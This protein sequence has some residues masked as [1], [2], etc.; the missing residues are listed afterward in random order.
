MVVVV[1]GTHKTGDRIRGTGACFAG[2]TPYAQVVPT[3]R[4]YEQSNSFIM[5]RRRRRRSVVSPWNVDQLRGTTLR[6][7]RSALRSRG[8]AYALNRTSCHALVSVTLGKCG[9]CR[10][11]DGPRRLRSGQNL[12]VPHDSRNQRRVVSLSAL[13][14]LSACVLLRQL[15]EVH[16][17]LQQALDP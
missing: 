3:Y 4:C 17:N 12:D 10:R 13:S 7:I 1:H 14:I 8:D 15:R 2:K 5:R 16:H 9:G 6:G 11:T